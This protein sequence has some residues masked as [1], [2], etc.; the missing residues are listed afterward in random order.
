MHSAFEATKIKKRDWS[1][2]NFQC[3]RK[4]SFETG[5]GNAV[6]TFNSFEV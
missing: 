3:K 6:C 1:I 4:P 2:N 5:V